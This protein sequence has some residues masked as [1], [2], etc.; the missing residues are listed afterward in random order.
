MIKRELPEG[1]ALESKGF[2]ELDERNKTLVKA[3]GCVTIN[4]ELVFE[5][6]ST[7]AS[8][9]ISNQAENSLGCRISLVRDIILRPFICQ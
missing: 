5:T 9:G 6:G 7:G 8:A 2:Y 4:Q 3:L 1:K